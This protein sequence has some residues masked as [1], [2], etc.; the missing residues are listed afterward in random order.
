MEFITFKQ[1]IYTINVRQYNEEC[2]SVEDRHDSQVIRLYWKDKIDN[3]IDIGWYDFDRK[4]MVWD[5]LSLFLNENI[6]N[7]IVTNVQ[8]DIEM[9]ELKVY[10]EDKKDFEDLDTYAN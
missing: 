7:S 4:G 2:S 5:R 9:N 6:L 1:F 8:L 3:W 10:L